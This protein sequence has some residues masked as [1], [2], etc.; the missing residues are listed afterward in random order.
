[1]SSLFSFIKPNLFYTKDLWYLK[2]LLESNAFLM[3]LSCDNNDLKQL[4]DQ[5]VGFAA[6]GMIFI[7]WTHE[8]VLQLPA[9]GLFL[10]ISTEPVACCWCMDVLL[11]V[12]A[13]VAVCLMVVLAAAFC[14]AIVVHW[15]EQACLFCWGKR[16]KKSYVLW[17]IYMLGL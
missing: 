10:R 11:V 4:Q 14:G 17:Y 13:V 16:K 5:L 15:G 6:F 9:D 2:E 8:E 7:T 3:Y 1:M 12:V